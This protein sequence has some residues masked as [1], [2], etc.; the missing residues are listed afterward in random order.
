MFGILLYLHSVVSVLNASVAQWIEH[1]TSD[2]RVVGSNPAGCTE[3]R[4]KAFCRGPRRSALR[5]FCQD[6]EAGACPDDPQEEGPRGG[7]EMQ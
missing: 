6:S 1:L 3:K 2:Q 5:H 4:R 7:A